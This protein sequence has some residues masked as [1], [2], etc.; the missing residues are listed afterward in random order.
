LINLVAAIFLGD[1]QVF[2]QE[3]GIHGLIFNPQQ[4]K[5]RPKTGLLFVTSVEVRLD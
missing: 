2:P 3:L 1:P 4:R 5:R